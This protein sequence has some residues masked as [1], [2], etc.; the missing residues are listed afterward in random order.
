[1]VINFVL[2]A[3]LVNFDYESGDPEIHKTF[4]RNRES[5]FRIEKR[6]SSSPARNSVSK[7][8]ELIFIAKRVCSVRFLPKLHEFIMITNHLDSSQLINLCI[9]IEWVQFDC[10]PTAARHFRSPVSP[11]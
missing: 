2:N 11:F 3:L 10:E 8:L 4:I 6:A 1:M 5:P 9:E 7:S